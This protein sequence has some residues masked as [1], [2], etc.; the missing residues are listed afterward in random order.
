MSA[1]VL[2]Y[3]ALLEDESLSPAAT[4]RDATFG[5]CDKF[6]ANLSEAMRKSKDTAATTEKVY[7]HIYKLIM[8]EKR[9]YE[10]MIYEYIFNKLFRPEIE[11]SKYAVLFSVGWLFY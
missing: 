7:N 3:L 4:A 9:P 2:T 10:K 5:T 1:S 11:Q 6:V 8:N